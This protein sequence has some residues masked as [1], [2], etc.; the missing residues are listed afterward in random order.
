MIVIGEVTSGGQLRLP[1]RFTIEIHTLFKRSWRARR[2]HKMLGPPH[3]RPKLWLIASPRIMPDTFLPTCRSS[4]GRHG[5]RVNSRDFSTSANRPLVFPGGPGPL[6]AAR[7]AGV[8]APCLLET[9]HPAVLAI[10]SGTDHVYRNFSDVEVA[11]SGGALSFLRDRV[12]KELAPRDAAT[13]APW[14]IA[15]LEATA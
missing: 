5:T 7:I 4:T 3:P 9:G 14:G 1:G 12:R 2:L 13:L 11:I 6:S 15:W 10:G 8:G